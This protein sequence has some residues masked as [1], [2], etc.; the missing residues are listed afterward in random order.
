MKIQSNIVETIKPATTTLSSKQDFSLNSQYH[1]DEL[2]IHNR[3][4]NTAIVLIIAGFTVIFGSI[5]YTIFTNNLAEGLLGVIS[6]IVVDAISSVLFWFVTKSSE[7]KWKYF[8]ALSEDNEENKIIDLIKTPKTT[9]FQ[10]KMIEKLVD[11]Y[12]ESRK[13]KK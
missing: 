12:C 4:N 9:E 3:I 8:G 10:E 2:K 11:T 6:G 1:F 5:I 7:D 13:R